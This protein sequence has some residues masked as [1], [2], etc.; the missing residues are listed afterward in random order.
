[1]VAPLLHKFSPPL[2]GFLVQNSNC[3]SHTTA[4]WPCSQQPHPNPNPTPGW[5]HQDPLLKRSK[6]VFQKVAPALGVLLMLSR[7]S[8]ACA[9]QPL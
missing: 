7:A 2:R 8:P 6:V 5:D 1:M 3:L 4:V 9:Q